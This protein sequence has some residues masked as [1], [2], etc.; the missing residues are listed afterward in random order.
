M[1]LRLKIWFVLHNEVE[2]EGKSLKINLAIRRHLYS[3][4]FDEKKKKKNL[5]I[6]KPKMEWRDSEQREKPWNTIILE[7]SKRAVKVFKD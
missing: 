5:S 6:S 2:L 1:G 3:N 4:K 7:K